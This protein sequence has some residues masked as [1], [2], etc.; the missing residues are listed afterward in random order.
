[1][2]GFIGCLPKVAG[3]IDL[4]SVTDPTDLSVLSGIMEASF[5]PNKPKVNG[6]ARPPWP[7]RSR[8]P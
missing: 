4:S 8:R 7:S 5:S 2:S 1:M 3:I 6:T